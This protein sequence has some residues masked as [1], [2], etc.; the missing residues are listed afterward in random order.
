MGNENA[1]MPAAN[2][3]ASLPMANFP[4]PCPSRNSAM[5]EIAVPYAMPRANVTR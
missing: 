4:K 3:A 1:T 5:T 2:Q